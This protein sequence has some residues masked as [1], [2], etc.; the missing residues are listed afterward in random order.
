M[1]VI[2]TVH[3]IPEGCFILSKKE[4]IEFSQAAKAD[5][6]TAKIYQGKIPEGN[7]Y[8]SRQ[9]GR[10]VYAVKINNQ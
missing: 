3:T 10:A 8:P 7:C 4:A 9:N 1:E 5:G 6:K 2:E